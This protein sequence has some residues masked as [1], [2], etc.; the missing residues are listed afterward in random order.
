MLRAFYDR[1]LLRSYDIIK[2]N[3]TPLNIET[4]LTGAQASLGAQQ[5]LYFPWKRKPS[6]E[7]PLSSL[8]HP[9]APWDAVWEQGYVKD[10]CNSCDLNPDEEFSK[11][12][13]YWE[14]GRSF[15]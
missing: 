12:N 10:P 5:I 9:E 15:P 11:V 13:N 3:V 6:R 7:V 4:E 1:N 8:S 14:K 2:E